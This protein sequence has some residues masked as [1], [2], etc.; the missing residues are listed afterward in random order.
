MVRSIA[1][2]GAPS[3]AGAYAP[4]QEM[5][6]AALR[7][8]GLKALLEENN[9]AYVDYGDVDGFRW[10]ADRYSPRAMNIEIVARVASDVATLVGKAACENRVALVLG[11]DCTVELGT[12]AGLLR[13]TQNLGLIYV[14]HDADMNTPDTTHDGALDWMG[15]AH[16]LALPGADERLTRLGGR[17]PL[18]AP[19][20]VMLFAPGN[21][22]ACERDRIDA[23]Q[24]KTIAH[25][26]VAGDP[27]GAARAAIDWAARFDALAIHFDVDVI[28]FEDFPIAENTRRKQALALGQAMTALSVLLSAPNLA[29]LTISEVN[30]DHGAKDG[31]TI[32]A[33]AARL[34]QALAAD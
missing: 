5:A 1:I 12:V 13:S 34:A 3:S 4:G 29:A 2:I 16:M 22:K 32:S 33:F 30:P 28:D 31:S 26:A 27:A 20:A 24:I 18:L 19:E 21:I 14:D 11:G 6:P 8:A 17:T 9:I 15:V 7:A 25:A 23:L 10:R